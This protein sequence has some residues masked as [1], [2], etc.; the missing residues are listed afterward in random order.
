MQG[1]AEAGDQLLLDAKALEHA[2]A[3]AVVLEAVP[4]DLGRRVTEELA[5]PTIGIGAGPDTDA[6]V[7]V[8]QDL[9]GLTGGH[10]P[11]FVKRYADMAGILDEAVSKYVAEVS[12]GEYPGEEHSYK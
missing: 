7:M 11:K 5:I 4:T 6:Q 3:F 9:V 10:A 8:W 12:S 2:G 1:R